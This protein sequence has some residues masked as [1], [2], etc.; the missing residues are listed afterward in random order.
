MPL[1]ILGRGW[2]AAAKGGAGARAHAHERLTRTGW[3]S[4]V[5]DTLCLFD[6]S[7]VMV[8][9]D[10]RLPEEA[11]AH[12][13]ARMA[14]MFEQTRPDPERISAV[15]ADMYHAVTRLGLLSRHA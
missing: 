12:V 11:Q 5:G 4:E 6:I 1:A 13:R 9:V 7:C 14:A 15:L 8:Q 10:P 2:T 3:V